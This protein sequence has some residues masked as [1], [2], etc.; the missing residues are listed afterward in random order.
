MSDKILIGYWGNWLHYGSWGDSLSAKGEL[1]T[2]MAPYTHICYMPTTLSLNIQTV[3]QPNTPVDPDKSVLSPSTPITF[4]WGANDAFST[5]GRI[6]EGSDPYSGWASQ[7]SAACK[8][9]GKKF[10]LT[11]GGWSDMQDTPL[12]T[13]D[14]DD[15]MAMNIVKNF[16]VAKDLFHLDGFDFDWEHLSQMYYE[17]GTGPQSKIETVVD[18][19]LFLGRVLF[20]LRQKSTGT[21]IYTTRPNTFKGFA[22]NVGPE[23]VSASDREGIII[24][25]GALWDG[26]TDR[27]QYRD[28]LLQI[29]LG[30]QN[31]KLT[32]EN[33]KTFFGIVNYVNMMAYDI[34][35]GEYCMDGKCITELR[36]SDY[37]VNGY[38]RH[39]GKPDNYGSGFTINES[40]QALQLTLDVIGKEYAN[41]LIW[42][43]SPVMQAPNASC[44]S[45]IWEL[46]QSMVATGSGGNGAQNVCTPILNTMTQ[47]QASKQANEAIKSFVDNTANLVG[48]YMFWA[49]NDPRVPSNAQVAPQ[50]EYF[51]DI[52]G[53][54]KSNVC[55]WIAKK[56]A[57]QLNINIKNDCLG[58]GASYRKS[59][60]PM[61]FKICEPKS[62]SSNERICTSIDHT[63]ASGFYKLTD[64]ASIGI[65]S[66][67]EKC[68][69]VVVSDKYYC[70]GNICTKVSNGAD[71]PAGETCYQND[72]S[73]GGKYCKEP[74]PPASQCKWWQTLEDGK[75][76]D[77]TCSTPSLE[78]FTQTKTTKTIAWIV[79]VLSVL[80]FAALFLF[81]KKFSS[82]TLFMS[83]L[84]I[85]M[86]ISIISFVFAIKPRKSE[87]TQQ[88]PTK[89]VQPPKYQCNPDT[90]KCDLV[91]QCA[92]PNENCFSDAEQD[93]CTEAC[94]PKSLKF[95]RCDSKTG[96]C[97]TNEIPCKLNE[98]D[99]T[100]W[101]GDTCKSSCKIDFYACGGDSAPNSGQLASG[102]ETT[103]SCVPVTN[104]T[105]KADGTWITSI[106]KPCYA[107]DSGCGGTCTPPS[108]IQYYQ[109]QGTDCAIVTS[110]KCTMEAPC[111]KNDKTCGGTASQ[112]GC[113]VIQPKYS[114]CDKGN[115]TIT[116]ENCDTTHPGN[117]FYDD[118][119]GS[120]A[121]PQVNY[122][123]CIDN[124][125]KPLT[126]DCSKTNP[127]NCFTNEKCDNK[128]TKPTTQCGPGKI[129]K[130]NPSTNQSECVP[131]DCNSVANTTTEVKDNTTYCVP[132]S[133]GQSGGKI[134][135]GGVCTNSVQCQKGLCT[136]INCGNGPVG[137]GACTEAN[138]NDPWCYNRENR[139]RDNEG[140]CLT[141]P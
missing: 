103:N 35:K 76:I 124:E 17:S 106:G 93:K 71:C 127:D 125:C 47:L 131:C 92:N 81:K 30:T 78:M 98:K 15:V 67:G 24:A 70:S 40:V 94:A 34:C 141:P 87:S 60:C 121:C 66:C 126:S 120:Q 56:I 13:Q 83:V 84:S 137:G 112:S 46:T 41:T 110:D 129:L 53:I 89:P 122:F 79:F 138:K 68:G 104:C 23:L 101:Q 132:C 111:F 58:N 5:N 96:D 43:I 99:K 64:F 57:D 18:R 39:N 85:V 133:S 82:K 100:C 26:K 90:K 11:L 21:I 9:L 2:L 25:Y 4:S 115:C 36:T 1:V 28:S 118:H 102:S 128:C 52:E 22:A 91:A 27:T 108:D 86:L 45:S 44:F 33:W 117:C 109:C 73:C 107:S 135:R 130:L 8:K 31:N 3:G 42:G 16:L 97:K 63:Y 59:E 95:S 29:K 119:C 37:P 19:C 134:P 80:G 113:T 105:P 38:I 136:A 50:N 69:S 72:D 48:G 14:P 54:R 32:P 77:P 6:Q 7:I 65:D 62:W 20:L 88:Q 114:Y 75:C 140:D 49:L 116:P 12:F 55:Y 51:T 61:D 74:P 139:C 123:S 10:I